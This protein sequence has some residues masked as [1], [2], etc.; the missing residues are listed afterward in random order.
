PLLVQLKTV[1]GIIEVYKN[2]HW[3]D[4]PDIYDSIYSDHVELIY[5][6]SWGDCLSGC[7]YHRYWKF[8]VYFDCRVEYVGSYGNSLPVTGNKEKIEKT[9]T[10]Y[11]NPFKEAIM[12]EGVTGPFQYTVTNLLGQQVLQGESESVSMNNLKELLPGLYLLTIQ[13]NDRMQTFRIIKE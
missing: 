13:E 10:V 1:P 4:G 3:Y 12:V 5:D 8:K 7:A 9:L 2:H 11:P 6:Y